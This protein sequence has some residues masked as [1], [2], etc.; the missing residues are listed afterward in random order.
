VAYRAHKVRRVGVIEEST[1]MFMKT[2]PLGKICL[3]LKEQ[4]GGGGELRRAI[5]KTRPCAKLS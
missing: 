5:C 2:R 1:Q 3:R 4:Q